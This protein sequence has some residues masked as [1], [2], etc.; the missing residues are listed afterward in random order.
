MSDE[1][2]SIGTLV[3]WGGLAFVLIILL[4]VAFGST[5]QVPAGSRGVLKTFQA[6]S[7]DPLSEGLHFITPLGIQ[8]VVMINV[9]TQNF[10][11][12]ESASSIDLLDVITSVSVNYHV[13]PL[14]A[15]LMYQS[16]GG[17]D[18]IES[19][20]LKP[21][22]QDT[23]RANTAKY[24]AEEL[25]KN[26]ESIRT[27]IDDGLRAVMAT[28]HVIIDA[29]YLTNFVYP[30]S[31]NEAITKSQT[32]NKE[33]EAQ[34]NQLLVEQYLAQQKVVQAQGEANST[35]VKAQA[36]AQALSIK[37]Q[38]IRANPEVIQLNWIDKWDGKVA[39]FNF[40]GSGSIPVLNLP[41]SIF[42]STTTSVSTA[43][44]SGGGR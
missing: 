38:A 39:Q 16:V 40:G 22:I 14:F 19:V 42:G 37:G 9:Q 34:K 29:V 18:A 11:S 20:I 15:P 8:N 12:D 5:V 17:N 3:K 10:A 41:N 32:A 27:A 6:V 43:V 31:F 28:K 2:I 33:A 4:A 36:E 13:D 26:R 21:A 25:V 1:T 30:Q 44:A 24:K 7:P 23:V 35:L